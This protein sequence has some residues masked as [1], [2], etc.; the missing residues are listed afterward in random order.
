ML[1][2]APVNAA[3]SRTAPEPNQTT[4][5]CSTSGPR[6]PACAWCGSALGDDAPRDAGKVWCG[7]CGVA[8]TSPWPTD[9]QLEAAYG[10][11]Y[12]PESGRFGGVGDALLRRARSTLARRI[13]RTAPA[14]R[15]LDVG[16]GDGTLVS[17]LRD[18]G[19]D[20]IGLER[21]ATGEHMQGGEIADV[22]GTWAAIVFWHSLEHLREPGAALAHAARLLAPGGLLVVALPNIASRQAAR[23]GDR[24]FALDLPR[25]LVHVPAAALTAKLTGVGLHVGRVSHLRGGQVAFGWAHGLVGRLPGHPDLYDAIRAPQARSAP[26]SNA[27]RLYAIAAAAVLSPVAMLMAAVE[28]VTRRGGSVYVEARR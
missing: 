6:T 21:H 14:G 7:Q 23:F 4:S 27:A 10:D 18:R 19:R 26:M 1:E 17:A 12:R 5:W 11:W 22:T 20:A 25:H 28:V 8:T 15:V 16:A 24:W 9:A 13:D 2:P 3:Q